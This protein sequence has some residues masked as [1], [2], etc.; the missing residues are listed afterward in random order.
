MRICTSIYLWTLVV[1][2]F[3]WNKKLG[4]RQARRKRRET[5]RWVVGGW[6]AIRRRLTKDL[7]RSKRRRIQVWNRLRSLVIMHLKLY[8]SISCAYVIQNTTFSFVISPSSLF[9]LVWQSVTAPRRLNAKR[10]ISQSISFSLRYLTVLPRRL[11]KSPSH[12]VCSAML[13]K[14]ALRTLN[15]FFIFLFAWDL[16]RQKNQI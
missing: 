15:F 2:V 12:Y 7:C 9:F 14:C 11:L 16:N 5:S 10:C 3:F 4:T 6:A 8:N 13:Y 1:F